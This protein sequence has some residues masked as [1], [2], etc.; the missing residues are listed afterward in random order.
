MRVLDRYIVSS[1]AK[2]FFG[3]LISFS[4]GIVALDYFSRLDQF[5]E[6][7]R[8]KGTFAEDFSEARVIF[9]FY[10]AFLPFLLKEVLPFVCVAAGLFTLTAMLH[11]NE[12]FP[13]VAAGVSARRLFLPLFLCGAVLSVGYM[14]FQEFVVPR[15]SRE[16][17]LIKRYFSG[18]RKPGVGN[19]VHLRDGHGTVTRVRYYR[20]HDRSLE[21]VVVQRPWTRAGFD[22]WTTERLEP[23]GTVWTAPQG[24]HLQPAGVDSLPRRL[25]PGTRVDIGV[26]PY[27][28]DAL[29]SKR[30]TS[31]LSYS[32]LK[33]LVDKFPNRRHLRVALHKQIARPFASLVLLLVGVPILLAAGRSYF[34]GAG[35][36]FAVSV[37]YYCLDI[38]FTSLGDR[39]DLP[40][41]FAAYF[42]LAFLLS[43]GVA[44]LATVPT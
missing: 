26:S 36:A 33:T 12:V 44:R 6:L 18:D 29:A 17:I 31:E 27:E 39:G 7:H 38:F 9:Q 20:F 4:V 24:V 40:A 23:A 42:P 35:V 32:Q 21:D 25:P 41:I 14:L 3:A 10:V 34:L 2:V 8:L 28:V 22:L 1:F 5:H 19:L 15:L 43:L 11:N 13:V 30:A 16:Q 37:I